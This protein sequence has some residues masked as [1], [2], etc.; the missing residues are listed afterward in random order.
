MYTANS[1]EV[2][3][4]IRERQFP[5]SLDA[6]KLEILKC[7]HS[8]V[9]LKVLNI[10]G[11]DVSFEHSDRQY[12]IVP[13]VL[14]F[15]TAENYMQR[16]CKIIDDISKGLTGTDPCVADT[17]VAKNY[18]DEIHH[19]QQQLYEVISVNMDE[20]PLSQF[21]GDQS[22]TYAQYF[23]NKYGYRFIN[24]DQPS[25]TC[26]AL[27]LGLNSLRLASS[28]HSKDS[29]SRRCIKNEIKL[30]PELCHVWPLSAFLW[31]SFR[32]IPTLL[33][34]LESLMLIN[35]LSDHISTSTGIGYYS[36][37][38][39][40][41]KS[42]LS[43]DDCTSRKLESE[44]YVNENE[45]VDSKLAID[46]ERFALQDGSHRKPDNSI[47]LRSL[48]TRSANDS[49]NLERLETLGDSF[50]KLLT[51]IDLF[52]SRSS[53]HEGK[54]TTARK[55]RIS[56]FNL[57]FLAKKKG[58][59]GKLLTK[60]F[61]PMNSW[62]PPCFC[63]HGVIGSPPGSAAVSPNTTEVTKQVL[64]YCYHKATD[65]TVADSV[66]AMLGAYLIA[67]GIEAAIIWL[68]WIGLKLSWTSDVEMKSR[69]SSQ[70]SVI[71]YDPDNISMATVSSTDDSSTMI[72]ATSIN[73]P[74]LVSHSSPIF[75]SCGLVACSPLL[76]QNGDNA[77][78]LV[79]NMIA[80]CLPR[81]P[82]PEYT[83]ASLCEKLGW[84][85]AEPALLLQALT[86][87]SYQKN[88]LTDYYQR[89]EFL[90]DAVL[91]YLITC[92]IFCQFPN[93]TPGEITNARSALVNNITFAEIAVK[94][95]QLHKYLLH[96]SPFLFSQITEYVQY[97]SSDG[98]SSEQQSE[99]Y[100]SSEDSDFNVDVN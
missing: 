70:V 56:N 1:D 87:P 45:T 4:C 79:H 86:H 6:V 62:I 53:D 97:L 72:Q 44:F 91:D 75:R 38:E 95:L 48:T 82:R 90:G 73:L 10:G 51:T 76:G 2:S 25:L 99:I 61:E 89:L 16:T 43:A 71:S 5:F 80:S 57:C 26:K 49:V 35:E 94:D 36:D 77:Y 42:L 68:C 52:C 13:T 19:G 17:L 21:P 14:E 28:T 88:R 67:G 37:Y 96:S 30:F 100:C 93:Y 64:D 33:Y 22:I 24:Y 69:S 9:F 3:V 29:N 11:L 46:L 47:L 78:E 15:E 58:L 66:E 83:D 84:N 7:F 39:Y 98:T 23:L 65:K 8:E 55:R 12:L 59:P 41:T 27:S 92:Y 31:K 63:L 50:L 40:S 85:F 20:T 32:C 54:L 34:R 60:Q 74:L 81:A 18:T